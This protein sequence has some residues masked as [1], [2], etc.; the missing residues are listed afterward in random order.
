M[1]VEFSL[2]YGVVRIYRD[3]DGSTSRIYP[4]PFVRPTIG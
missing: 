4:V 1:K 2:R 3:R